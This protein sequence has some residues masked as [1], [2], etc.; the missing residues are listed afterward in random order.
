MILLTVFCSSFCADCY[1]GSIWA[2]RGR[3]VAEDMYSDDIAYKIGNVLTIVVNE[4][5][6]IE[7]ETERSLQKSTD[8]SV[9]FDGELNI[10]HILPSMPGVKMEATSDN[11]LDGQA[12][13]E[14][15]RSFIDAVTVVVVDVQPN[16][17][18]IVLGSRKRDVGGDIQ[19]VEISGIVRPS[20][21]NFDNTVSSR[22]VADF[23]VIAKNQGVSDTYTDP[24][25]LG[26]I[27]DLL[28]PF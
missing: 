3:N 4:S 25:W 24:G 7:N 18:L 11:T 20:D 22:R 28:W 5:S 13:Y 17:N 2:K 10:D 27:F 21:I 23:H 14:D 9:N 1:G 12:D 6:I 15:E 8:R 16:G 26:S 19:T